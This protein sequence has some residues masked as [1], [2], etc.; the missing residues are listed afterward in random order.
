MSLYSGGTGKT[1]T[2]SCLLSYVRAKGGIALA[3][4]LSAVASKLMEGGSTLHSKLKVPINISKDSI[5]SFNKNTTV[6]KL[7]QQAIL[8][9][10][11]EVSMGH[12]HIYEAVDRSLREV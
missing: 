11:D 7:M 5:C 6:G 2:I 9:V 1:F 8:L 3:T 10:I 4:A 12:K